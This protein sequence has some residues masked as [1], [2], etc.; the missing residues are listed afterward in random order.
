MVSCGRMFDTFSLLDFFNHFLDAAGS[1]PFYAMAYFIWYGGWIVFLWV[2]LWFALHQYKDYIQGKFAA[3]R[4]WMLLRITVPRSS[5]QTP[6][7][8]ENLFA[9]LA[10]THGTFS[11]VEEWIK[12]MTQSQLA[13]EIVSIDGNVGY[14]VYAE[15][16]FQD[17]IEASIHAQYPDADVDE[18]PDYVKN[19]PHHFP[20]EEWDTFST[21]MVSAGKGHD[22]DAYP[23]RTYMEF[24]D[25]VSGEF[26][27]P[28]AAMLEN[29]SRLGPGEQ[30]WYQIVLTPIGQTDFVKKCMKVANKLKGKEEKVKKSSLEQAIMLPLELLSEAMGTIIGIGHKEPEKKKEQGLYPKLVAMSGVEREILESIERKSSKIAFACKIRFCY[31]AKKTVMK[32]SRAVHPFIGAM[33]QLNT[34]DRFALKPEGKH[35]GVN[36][37]LLLFKDQRN[38]TRRNHFMHAYAQRSNWAGMPSFMLNIEELA[39]LWHFPI[40]M[41]VKAPSLLRTQAKKSEPPSNIPFG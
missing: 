26:K 1:N 39:T 15:R 20:D 9:H 6:R 5:E 2:F 10:G 3:S 4:E 36:G 41:Q 24:V 16:K 37:T 40:L 23:L 11:F 30:V 25:T 31:I 18:V 14:Y 35:V 13:V 28:M 17:L 27:D 33:K 21:E 38:N 12:G 7:A 19:V 22:A 8:V 34:N 29:L 32:K